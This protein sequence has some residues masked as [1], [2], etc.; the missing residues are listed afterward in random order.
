[1]SNDNPLLT[2][3]AEQIMCQKVITVPSDWSVDRLARF[4]TD[5]AISGAPVVNTAGQ[6]I[7]VVSFSDIVRQAGSGLV[8]MARRDNDFYSSLYSTMDETLSPEDQRSFHDIID[9]SVLVN[10]IMTPMVFEVSLETPLIQVA[11]AM[12]KGRIHRVMVTKDG[13]LKGVIS[14][15]DLLKV[16][17]L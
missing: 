17:T 16:M 3:T 15:L 13:S 8:D 4:L 2:M 14:A 5:K 9:Q 11:E 6:L 10:D 7:G 1:M 12:V